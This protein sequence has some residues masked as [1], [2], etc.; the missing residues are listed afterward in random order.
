MLLET[1][2]NDS[3]MIN[4]QH[5]ELYCL[6]EMIPFYEKWGFTAELPG[7]YLMRKSN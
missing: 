2:M 4:V 5:H 3:A 6:K 1:V 7:L